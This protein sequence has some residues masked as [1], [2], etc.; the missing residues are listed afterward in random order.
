MRIAPPVQYNILF[1][2][3]RTA[4]FLRSCP[5]AIDDDD[6][7]FLDEFD[8]V[9]EDSKKKK[10]MIQTNMSLIRL[11]VQSIGMKINFNEKPGSTSYAK[12]NIDNFDM[13]MLNLIVQ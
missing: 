13:S 6:A 10:W 1:N 12:R 5:K 7:D 4:V 9:D 11:K 8:K 2:T 3:K